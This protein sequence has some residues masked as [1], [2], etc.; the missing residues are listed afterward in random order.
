[1][2][3]AELVQ[4]TVTGLGYEL[5]EL[6]RSAG[7]MLRITIDW[8]WAGG[9]GADVHTAVTTEDCERVTRQLQFALEVEAVDYKRLEVASPGLDRPLRHEADLQR[10]VG[11]Q[12]EVTLKAAIGAEVAAAAGGAVN[13][14][15]KKFRGRLEAVDGKWQLAWQDDVLSATLKVGQKPGKR[16]LQRQAEAPWHA[17]GFEW[18]E[19]R[20]AR[21]VPLVDFKGRGGA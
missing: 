18:H 3:L 21:L 2:A 4:N 16:A 11:E 8:P 17:L 1:M 20:E 10:F 9:E 5:V 12:I 13:A 14:N 19:L 15:R 7:G 6:E